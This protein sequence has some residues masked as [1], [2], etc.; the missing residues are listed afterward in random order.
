MMSEKSDRLVFVD[1]D[2][3]LLLANSFHML[4][5]A[6]VTVRPAGWAPALLRFFARRAAPGAGART[7]AKAR[8]IGYLD[9][10]GSD[11]S[12]EL[13]CRLLE[14]MQCVISEPVLQIVREE[15]E[16]GAT[17]VLATA[18]PFWYAAPASERLGFDAVLA[19]TASSPFVELGGEAKAAACR[20]M[21][22]SAGQPGTSVH[23]ITDHPDDC[24]L[25]RLADELTVHGPANSVATKRLC[26]ATDG[27]VG[28]VDPV[29]SESGGGIWLWVEGR[30][31][32]PLSPWDVC[33]AMTKNRYALIFDGGWRRLRSKDDVAQAR[34]RIRAPSAPSARER[35]A[36]ALRRLFVRRWL[37]I[38]H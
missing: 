29:G 27:V 24:P 2:G 9:E 22:R 11:E 20:E 3:T 1:L 12:D 19:T 15:Q 14:Q 21:I 31:S 35:G 5:E 38:F 18:A 4:L 17:V 13:R 32:G 7:A 6:I 25:A 30:F 37:R 33:L 23:V 34:L 36:L 10:L 8:I 28:V 26:Q 16:R